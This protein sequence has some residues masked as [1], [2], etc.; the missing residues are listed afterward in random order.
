M[1]SI[2]KNYAQLDIL[3]KFHSHLKNEHEKWHEIKSKN[4]MFHPNW[5][6]AKGRLEQI[7]ELLSY[8]EDLNQLEEE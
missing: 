7:S 3:F 8:I 1:L 4:R 5:W 2:I 6:R